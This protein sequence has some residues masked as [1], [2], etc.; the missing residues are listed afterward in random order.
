MWRSSPKHQND[1]YFVYEPCL[2]VVTQYKLQNILNSRNGFIYQLKQWSV[3]SHLK[4]LNIA[5][6]A[7][8][9]FACFLHKLLKT[10]K[11][12]CIVQN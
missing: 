9:P 2:D 11:P 12:S 6:I 3:R 5:D 8:F 10:Q 7:E 1:N 4:C